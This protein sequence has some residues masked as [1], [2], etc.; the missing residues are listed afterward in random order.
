MNPSS[1]HSR[2]W[3]EQASGRHRLS[4]KG[5]VIHLSRDTHRLC[6]ISLR[7]SCGFLNQ[8]EETLGFS[9]LV[10][11]LP[12]SLWNVT[13]PLGEDLC[14]P[15]RFLKISLPVSS[16][17]CCELKW[18]RLSDHQLC[19]TGIV[20]EHTLQFVWQRRF[21]TF[22]HFWRKVKIQTLGSIN[23]LTDFQSDVTLTRLFNIL[24]PLSLHLQNQL[25][26]IEMS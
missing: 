21:Q 4:H 11:V 15:F 24:V 25:P 19:I 14:I 8:C 3:N 20:L 13:L 1:L 2:E 18:M 7:H 9:E 12:C 10:F 5:A 26:P 16:T 6:G 17:R 23:P 22:S